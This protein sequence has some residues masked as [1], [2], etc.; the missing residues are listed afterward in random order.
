[1]GEFENNVKDLMKR[2]EENTHWRQ[3]KCFNLIPS[4]MT[5]SVLVKMCEIADPSGRYAEHRTMK[6]NE[7]YFYQG[8]DFIREVE[9]KVK[10][11]MRKYFNCAEIE[12]R[13]ISGQMANEVVF[14]ALVKFL[15]RDRKEG[16]PQ[17][18]MKLVMN[19]LLTHGGHLSSQP[20]G[21]LF[22]YVDQFSDFKGLSL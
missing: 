5:A 6:G 10:D 7:V 18:R 4:E 14:K 13:P 21:A 9:D 16:E 11:E 17:R 2:A 19:N 3:K 12:P 22:N 1:M 15:N 20:M 8:I